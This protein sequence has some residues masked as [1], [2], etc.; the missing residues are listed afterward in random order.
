M[1]S[2]DAM[3][4]SGQQVLDDGVGAAAALPGLRGLLRTV[5][6][7]EFAGTVFHEVEAKSALNR[8][9]G[10]SPMPFRWTVNP[11]RGCS[12]ACVYCLAGPTR[13]LLADGR[14][15]P[16]AELR[17]GD[18]VMGT[19][20]TGGR[21]RYVRTTVLAHWSTT[22]P[23]HRVRLAGGT[24]L[25][26]SGE[27]RFLTDRG[28]RHVRRRL[29]PLRTPAA[30]AP[31]QRPA[32]TRSVGPEPV[33][34]GRAHPPAYRQGY[35]CGLVRGDTG[36]RATPSRPSTSSWRR[37]AGP[38]T[39]SPRRRTTPCRPPSARPPVGAEPGRI[40]TASAARRHRPDRRRR[41]LAAPRRRRLV[42]RV[43]GRCSSTPAGGSADGRAAASR[44]P[45]IR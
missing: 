11:Y 12:H 8:V 7:P 6:T 43:P 22:K 30:A 37:S 26:A 39:S 21:R 1:C 35:L 13:V 9:P 34:R 23:A 15:R 10:T 32:R 20:L 24:E 40:P 38:T 3:R 29:V 28:W 19:E 14:T 33:T 44:T 36:A 4:W 42:R 5:R 41:A 2:N 16:I 31:G 17:V 25:V 27:H 45:T 18:A